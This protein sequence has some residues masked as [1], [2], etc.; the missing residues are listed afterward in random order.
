MVRAWVADVS[1]LESPECYRKYYEQLPDFRKA[2]A[3]ALKSDLMK[4]QSAGVWILWE[5]IREKYGLPGNAAFNLSHSG[6]YVMCAAEMD[7]LAARVGCD[8]E[9]IGPFK[10]KVA[11]RFFCPEEY[12]VIMQERTEEEKAE[13]FYR[14][15]VL[16]ESFMKA[17]G[18]GMA[19]PINS[20]C[21]RL[22]NPPLLVRRP[23]EFAEPYYYMEY[24]DK[25]IPCRMA[26]CS[27][28]CEIV[29]GLSMEFK[30]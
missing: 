26:V 28:D 5:K 10:E 24:R 11:G 18:M 13:Q 9:K 19:L 14:F 30:L 2:K 7:E 22:D 29:A 16:K 23:Q 21:I 27:T 25:A 4:A 17:T 15:W 6:T 8:L 1:P 3:D 12:E 20:F